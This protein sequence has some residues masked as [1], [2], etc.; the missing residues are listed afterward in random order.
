MTNTPR[1]KCRESSLPR[2]SLE[3]RPRLRPVPQK[4]NYRRSTASY[5]NVKNSRSQW[6]W[7]ARSRAQATLAC[8]LTRVSIRQQGHPLHRITC[9][10]GIV[11]KRKGRF[12]RRT[13]S[14]FT[15]RGILA[16]TAFRSATAVLVLARTLRSVRLAV[17]AVPIMELIGCNVPRP[18]HL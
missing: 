15:Q 10:R 8:A 4:A 7:V 2:H 14:R 5:N 1:P 16:A 13:P 11:R 18:T 3:S 9:L 6:A 12:D 17:G